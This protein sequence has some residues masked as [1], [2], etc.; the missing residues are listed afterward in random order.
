MDEDYVSG[1]HT[2]EFNTMGVDLPT[3]LCTTINTI[4]DSDVEGPH[5]FTV[6][7]ASVGLPNSVS[8]APPSEQSATI[9]DNDGMDSDH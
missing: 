3:A 8:I 6:E 1:P 9:S 5:I 7:I 2:V 4:D